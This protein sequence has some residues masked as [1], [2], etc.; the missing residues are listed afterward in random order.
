MWAHTHSIDAITSRCHT[1]RRRAAKAVPPKRRRQSQSTVPC[2]AAREPD[3][4]ASEAVSVRKF[5]QK[6]RS[7]GITRSRR[8]SCAAFRLVPKDHRSEQLVR[9]RD[10]ALSLNESLNPAIVGDNGSLL[11]DEVW[12]RADDH[13]VTAGCR[14]GGDRFV[15][16]RLVHNTWT[17]SRLSP[18]VSGTRR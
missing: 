9:K 14:M 17:A 10:E 5:R 8:R 15:P 2:L 6:S 13:R 16:A 4:A 18:L 1:L 12:A 7:H 3:L 11:P